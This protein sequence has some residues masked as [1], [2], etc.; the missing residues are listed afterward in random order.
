MKQQIS[1]PCDSIPAVALERDPANFMLTLCHAVTA[2]FE[3]IENIVIY[4]FMTFYRNMFILFFGFPTEQRQPLAN[5]V[6]KF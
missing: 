5:F 1:S 6:T 2:D 4:F 3:Y